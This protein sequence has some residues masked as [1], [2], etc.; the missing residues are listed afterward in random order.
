MYDFP[1]LF[2]T[3]HWCHLTGGIVSLS[4]EEGGGVE[5]GENGI[6]M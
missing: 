2:I 5:G 6:D 1:L 4:W 3:I